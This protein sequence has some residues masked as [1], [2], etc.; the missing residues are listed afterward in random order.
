MTTKQINELS[1]LTNEAS[2]KNDIDSL[3]KIYSLLQA[4]IK[5]DKNQFGVFGIEWFVSSLPNSQWTKVLTKYNE[6]K[7]KK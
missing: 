1:E 3:V 2:V 7:E 4:S 5:N 6:L